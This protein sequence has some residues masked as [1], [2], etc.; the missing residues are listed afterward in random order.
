M[1]PATHEALRLTGIPEGSQ[2]NL[3]HFDPQI[4]AVLAEQLHAYGLMPPHPIRVLRQR[5]LTVVLCEQ[6]ELALEHDIAHQIW[7]EATP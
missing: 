3:A 7:V 2:A 4:P 6:V 1:S 5:P